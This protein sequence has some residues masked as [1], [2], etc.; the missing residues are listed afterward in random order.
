MT[1]FRG[2]WRLVC[3]RP[4]LFWLNSLAI[5]I[6]FIT[7]MVPGFVARDFFNRLAAPGSADLGLWGIAAVLIMA[8]LGRIV[9]LLGCQLTNAPFMLTTAGLLQTN[10]LMRVLD[11]PAAT[12]LPSSAGE[13][14]SRF[15]DDVEGITESMI[16]FNDLTA[17]TVFAVVAL[18]VMISINATITIAVFVPLTIVVAVANLASRRIETYRRASREATGQVTGF[19]GELFGAV[20]AVQVAGA[21]EQVTA[22]FRSLNDTRLHATVRDRVFDQVLQSIFWNTV[23]V[24][25]GLILL[26][27]GQSMAG[28]RFTVGDLALFVYYLGWVTEFTALFGVVLARYRQ[29]GVA[30]GRLAAL[31]GGAP[32][33]TLVAHR[34]LHIEGPPAPRP[35]P[36]ERLAP[37]LDM[38]TV[39]GLSYQYPDTSRGVRDASFTLARGSFTVITGRIGSGK[40][41]LLE[42]LL[43]LLPPDGGE[44]LW[45]GTPATDPARFF[46]PP[47]SAYTP[48]VPRL[49]SDTLG[50]NILMGL[51][52]EP[53]AVTDAL[54]RA[55]L[56]PDVA[57]MEHGL[58][59]LIGARGV[60]LSGGQVQ[61]AAAARMFVRDPELFVCDDLSSALDVET[62]ARLWERV[63]ERQGATCL[64]VS[65]RQS[66]LRRADRILVLKEGRVEAEGRLEELLA[67][68]EEM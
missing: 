2:L 44:V 67:T 37:P 45:N 25:T 62:E 61:R 1:T 8:S 4:W 5:T 60:R 50:D 35:V 34:P 49:F 31:L 58:D 42:V 32:R 38:L 3:Y 23:N 27:A 54:H 48:Q 40:T 30:F 43:G 59:T 19:L 18:A 66:V 39:S 52:A 28:G 55:V 15:R 13:A 29:A 7:E 53:E 11:L 46:V 9:C 47:Q 16:T 68:S 57:A 41:T 56:E 10:L 22:H 12:A 65:H 6:V 36:P 17:S 21:D 63:F 33:T 20:Q 14:I 64:V 51:P 24:G 26:V